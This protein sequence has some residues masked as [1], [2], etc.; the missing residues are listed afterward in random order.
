MN[1]FRLKKTWGELKRKW[2]AP[3]IRNEVVDFVLKWTRKTDIAMKWF[4]EKV[5]ID[6]T[7]FVSWR[8][9]YGNLNAHNGKIPK[10]FWIEDWEKDAIVDFHLQHPFEGYRR[11]AFMMLDANVVH[12]CP[13]TVYRVLKRYNLMEAKRLH[14]SKKG[15]GFVQPVCP[16]EQ[17]HVDVTYVKLGGTF[18]YLS[19]IMDGFSRYIV[20]W[21][22][23]ESMKEWELEILI[24]KA[25]EKFPDAKPRIISDNGPQF[26]ARDFNEFINVNKL[27]HTRISPGYPQSNGKIER[28]NKTIKT[29]CIKRKRP[30]SESECKI[31]IDRFINDYNNTRLHSAIGYVAPKD[32][33]EG[34][35]AVIHEERRCKLRTAKERRQMKRAEI[36]KK[37]ISA[38]LEKKSA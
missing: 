13:S 29:E 28:C 26:V 24:Q 34:G 3:S 32:R 11:L 36:I 9:R 2:I 25:L 19:F 5:G 12:V 22:L 17:W 7:R 33:L 4:L 31:M 23:S 18:F 21:E 8:E 35:E 10:D 1:M 37:N 14:S 16:H 6:K 30:S 27:K 15:T 38:P 20:H